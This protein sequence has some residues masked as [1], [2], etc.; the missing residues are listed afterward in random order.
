MHGGRRLRT[1][2]AARALTIAAA[3]LVAACATAAAPGASDDGG[4]VD[5]S[6]ASDGPPSVDAA[7]DAAPPLPLRFGF[8][9]G[10]EGWSVAHGPLVDDKALWTA[11]DGNPPGA[12]WLDGSDP[13]DAPDVVANARLHRVIE[14]PAEATLLRFDTRADLDGALRVRVIEG[15]TVETVLL[16]WEVLAGVEWRERSAPID[17]FAGRTVT[18]A[19]EQ[20]DDGEG[21]GEHRFVD[22][23]VIE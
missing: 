20:D 6:V 14:L 16:D 15:G 7:P 1:S 3:S 9:S 11:T 2:V 10:L 23:I 5:G 13:D 8:D 21:N 18:L 17:A 4:A 22:N 19:F 12:I